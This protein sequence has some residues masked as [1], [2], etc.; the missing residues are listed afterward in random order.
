MIC[1][2]GGSAVS[3]LRTDCLRLLNHHLG[4]GIPPLGLALGGRRAEWI[5]SNS[6]VA[7]L[8]LAIHDL[9][10]DTERGDYRNEHRPPAIHCEPRP[11]PPIDASP[12]HWSNLRFTPRRVKARAEN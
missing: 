5:T 2:G 7:C 3:S 11:Q 12:C 6:A 8:P 4:V 1:G 10:F 9:P